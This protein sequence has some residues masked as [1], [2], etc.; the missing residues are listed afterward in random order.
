MIG[1]AKTVSFTLLL[2]PVTAPA[3]V[4]DG[5]EQALGIV[6][7]ARRAVE[8]LP[9]LTGTEAFDVETFRLSLRELRGDT[10]YTAFLTAQDVVDLVST[11]GT[12]S[13]QLMKFNIGWAAL[14]VNWFFATL[15][16]D[17]ETAEGLEA[18][19][20][21]L[22]SQNDWYYSNVTQGASVVFASIFRSRAEAG[23]LAMILRSSA[24]GVSIA[25]YLPDAIDP[26]GFIRQRM[27]AVYD[28]LT[29]AAEF[30]R[31][32]GEAYSYY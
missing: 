3:E 30:L 12:G 1:L 2:A 9:V 31:D 25:A 20:A 4:A 5:L 32:A 8:A 27:N 28:R 19:S 23:S 14:E 13:D 18:Q 29:N 24:A 6:G 15:L 16:G 22:M 17:S 26:E 11:A 7:S 10:P 21:V